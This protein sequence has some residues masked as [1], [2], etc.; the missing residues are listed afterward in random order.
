M[1]GDCRVQ[2]ESCRRLSMG[3][4]LFS[5]GNATRLCVV[6]RLLRQAFNGAA[7]LQSRKCLREHDAA[8]RRS[9]FNGAATLQ[10]RKSITPLEG[11]RDLASARA[12]MGPR[13]FS[14]GNAAL[15]Q[16]AAAMQIA[17][18]SMGPRLFSRGNLGRSGVISGQCFNGAATLQ[19]RKSPAAR[20]I[21][22]IRPHAL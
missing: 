9:C 16:E 8:T 4:R 6:R 18:A 17:E 20:P 2:G 15:R 12:L 11:R 21:C 3:P 19:S 14:R 13:L 7:T 1:C 5:R 10:S 22:K